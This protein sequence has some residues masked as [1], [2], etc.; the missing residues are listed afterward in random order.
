LLGS[1]FKNITFLI[2]AAIILLSAAVM[3]IVAWQIYSADFATIFISVEIIA[4]IMILISVVLFRK[5][6]NIIESSETEDS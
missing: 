4:S 3:R 2:S 6:E 5:K 1:I